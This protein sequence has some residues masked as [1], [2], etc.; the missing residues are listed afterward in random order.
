MSYFE[1]TISSSYM[2]CSSCRVPIS[3]ISSGKLQPSNY[4]FCAGCTTIYFLC[5]YS[6]AVSDVFILFVID[7]AFL[8]YEGEKGGGGQQKMLFVKLIYSVTMIQGSMFLSSESIYVALFCP[9]LFWEHTNA[10]FSQELYLYCKAQPQ[11]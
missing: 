6:Q 2:K 3:A 11:L 9:I 10:K 1:S 4:I 7:Q 8:L 5:N